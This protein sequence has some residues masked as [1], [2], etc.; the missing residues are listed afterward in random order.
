MKM[1]HTS[2]CEIFPGTI[3]NFGIAGDCLF[4]SGGIYVMTSSPTYYVYEADFNCIEA[5]KLYDEEIVKKI[6][7]RFQCLEEVAENLLCAKES[8][9]DQD[10]A[11]EAEDDWWLQGLRGECAV[12]MG[13][14]GC[15]DFDEQGTVYIVPMFGRESELKLIK[16]EI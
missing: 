16:K 6:A 12:K 3:S 8:L 2:P 7:Y 11:A 14:D 13:Y 15:Q 4:F 1:Y 5:C 9:F 10:F